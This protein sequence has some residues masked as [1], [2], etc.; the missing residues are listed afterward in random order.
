MTA[1]AIVRPLHVIE[2]NAIAYRRAW[3]IFVTGFFNPVLF[4]LSIGIGVGGLVGDLEVAGKVVPYKSFV[5]PALMA[6]AAMNGTVIDVTFGFFFLF[7]YSKSIHA[8]LATPLGVMDVVVGQMGWALLRGTIYSTMFLLVMAAMGLVESAWAVLCV[9][10]AMVMA[11]GFAGL[12]MA[13]TTYMRSFV[14]FDKINLALI[15][16]FLFS[17][18]FFPLSRYPEAAQWLVRATP[19]YQGVALLRSL[20]LGDINWAMLGHVA[21][22]LAMGAIGLRIAAARM[23]KL[24]QP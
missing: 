22:L 13:A 10:G 24:L 20:T 21:Y 6:T 19:L 23:A 17:A 5:A 9:P 16:L 7:K 18:T 4:L 12:G 1:A 2:R 15:P 11:F 8:M 3:K 14:D